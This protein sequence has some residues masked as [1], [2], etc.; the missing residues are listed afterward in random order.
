[1]TSTHQKSTYGN[2]WHIAQPYKLLTSKY[3]KY[4]NGFDESIACTSCWP[5]RTCRNIDSSRHVYCVR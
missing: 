4:D 2:G 3:I 5:A 1:M